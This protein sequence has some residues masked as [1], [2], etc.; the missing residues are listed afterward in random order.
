MK[1][2]GLSMAS[3]DP[4]ATVFFEKHQELIRRAYEGIC[5]PDELE[6]IK[7]NDDIIHYG[8]LYPS[9]N[10]A[11]MQNANVY[12]LG[13]ADMDELIKV[14]ELQREKFYL[15]CR[16]SSELSNMKGAARDKY[17]AVVSEIDKFL[18]E[19]G[20]RSFKNIIN[21]NK[22][23]FGEIKKSL[24]DDFNEG[25]KEAREKCTVG[26]NNGRKFVDSSD[27]DSC[28]SYINSNAYDTEGNYISNF[29]KKFVEKNRFTELSLID[30]ESLKEIRRI[31]NEYATKFANMSDEEFMEYKLSQMHLSEEEIEKYE[32]KVTDFLESEKIYNG[33]G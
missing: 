3:Y 5:N 27:D 19:L 7:K 14:N 9:H 30:I 31:L 1:H 18:A 33:R 26:V 11:W 16:L 2:M 17:L 10:Y 21:G 12:L 32:A 23:E 24:L 25:L 22:E 8:G 20:K 29:V 6:T 15:Y 28:Y 13:P 4:E